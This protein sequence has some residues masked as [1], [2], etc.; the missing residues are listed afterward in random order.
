MHIHIQIGDDAVTRY[1]WITR[2]ELRAQLAFLFAGWGKKDIERL[3]EGPFAIAFAVSM[4]EAMPDELS[5]AP[6]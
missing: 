6:F 5:I 2:V 3:I 4:R 1:G